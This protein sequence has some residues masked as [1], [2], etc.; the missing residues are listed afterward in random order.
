[1]SV[2]A[3]GDA[4][5]YFREIGGLL[6]VHNL[7]KSSLHGMVK[8]AALFT[9]GGLAENN[10]NNFILL[11]PCSLRHHILFLIVNFCKCMV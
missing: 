10:G 1:M 4:S 8:E 2:F 3:T 11:M 6:F 5:D 9:L 7:A